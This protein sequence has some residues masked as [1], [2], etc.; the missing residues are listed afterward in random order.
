MD[1]NT[2]GKEVNL[3]KVLSSKN[4]FLIAVISWAISYF[5]LGSLL[6]IISFFTSRICFFLSIIALIGE[7]HK[8]VKEGTRKSV[9][10]KLSLMLIIVV[11]V[12]VV[13]LGIMGS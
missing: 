3:K 8:E 11:I 9:N 6:N 12:V 2:L 4:L 1:S 13:I 5:D 7:Q 10:W